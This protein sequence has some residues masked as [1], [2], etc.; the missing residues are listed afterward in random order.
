MHAFHSQGFRLCVLGK[1]R[2]RLVISVTATHKGI[3][4]IDDFH[5]YAKFR[6]DWWIDWLTDYFSAFIY[7]LRSSRKCSIVI[8]TLFSFHKCVSWHSNVLEY[9]LISLHRFIK[10]KPVSELVNEEYLWI[11][12]AEKEVW[13]RM[14]FAVTLFLDLFLNAINAYHPLILY[15][16]VWLIQ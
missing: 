7:S 4:H 8:L 16:Y 5:V 11:L 6:F 2:A 3:Q 14:H 10:S 9:A 12:K 1:V 15:S 13:K